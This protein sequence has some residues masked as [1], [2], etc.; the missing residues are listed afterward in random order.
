[1]NPKRT[2]KVVLVA[3][4]LFAFIFFFERRQHSAPPETVRALP[5]F[6][7]SEVTGIQVLPAGFSEIRAD[8]TN[9]G[10]QLITTNE[11]GG[12]KLPQVYPAQK[13]AVEILLQALELLPRQAFI[14]AQEL[15]NRL[16]SDEEFGF[17]APQFT[18]IYQQAGDRREIR[19]G[20]KTTP[21][22][23]VYLQAVG[24]LGIEVVSAELL[25]L[26]PRNF[27]EW[28]S[29]SFINLAGLAFDKLAVTNSANVLELRRE[30]TNGTW[31]MAWPLQTRADT[32]KINGFLNRLE[33]LP[34]NRF[35]TDDPRADLEMYGLQPPQLELY[36]GK[37]TNRVLSLQFGK[38][39]T[40]DSSQV[41]A[42]QAGQNTIVQV[43]K[44][45][46]DPWR[47]SYV[48]F[49]D[50]NLVGGLTVPLETI[51]VRGPENFTVQHQTN[52][53]W[54]VTAPDNF[55]ADAALMQEF[56]TRLQQL[57]ISQFVK[58]VVP[59]GGL[60]NYGLAVPAREYVLK[61]AAGSLPGTNLVVAAVEFGKTNEDK[62][63]ARR[64]DRAD[65]S[66]VYAVKTA[67]YERL[68]FNSLQLRER[69]VWNFSP[70]AVTRL[71]VRLNGNTCQLDHKG[72]NLWSVAASPPRISFQPEEVEVAAQ[73]LGMLEAGAW[74]GHGDRIGKQYGLTNDFQI[75]MELKTPDGTE[76]KTLDFGNE[77]PRHGAYAAAKMPDGQSWVFEI[78]VGPLGRIIAYLKI[79]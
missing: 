10:W 52:G 15:K 61:A 23:Q 13:V 60:T 50:P 46:L 16:K 76:T 38:S 9:D 66:S 26:I 31:R 65:E 56:I 12:Q 36:F 74:V 27:N 8:R 68:P 22:D 69:R 53:S 57:Q 6:K 75:S 5:D 71:T 30:G 18:L 43:S 34:I 77:T 28:R 41:Y 62:T 72:S 17:D 14:K 70:E 48:E 29:T 7:A 64:A 54:R 67:D 11:V 51:E 33:S 32:A 39:A 1:M 63:F 24:T 42:R 35:E 59:E 4:C 25:K 73:E 44:A 49:R 47:A 19:I 78:P 58:D 2:W 37:G 40:N 79:K 3:A 20:A 21:G 55:P 45:M